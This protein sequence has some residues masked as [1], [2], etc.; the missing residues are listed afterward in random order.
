MTKFTTAGIT[1][2]DAR[3]Q[4]VEK[5]FQRKQVAILTLKTRPIWLDNTIDRKNRAIA[6]K[7]SLR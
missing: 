6:Q 5:V 2:T 4:E 3:R 7:F 1:L